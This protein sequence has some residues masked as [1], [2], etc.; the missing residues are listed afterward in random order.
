ME[1]EKQKT[2]AETAIDKK[3]SNTGENTAAAAAD[4]S[5][6]KNNIENAEKKPAATTTAAPTKVIPRKI[7]RARTGY[8]IF[9]DEMNE[10]IKA[11]VSSHF[12]L[13]FIEI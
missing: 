8:F 5:D 10:E 4:E 12:L 11:K 13:F 7:K 2:D 9:R 6:P 1:E 3:A